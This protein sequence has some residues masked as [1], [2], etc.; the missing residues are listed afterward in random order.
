MPYLWRPFGV[1]MFIDQSFVNGLCNTLHTSLEP[2]VNLWA[3]HFYPVFA[4]SVLSLDVSN[5][6]YIKLKFYIPS[7]VFMRHSLDCDSVFS[8]LRSRSSILEMIHHRRSFAEGLLLLMFP[9]P[10]SMNSQT[11]KPDQFLKFSR[12]LGY[13]LRKFC[14]LAMPS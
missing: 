11:Q 5:R 13:P 8:L 6:L 4:F 12:K 3:A 9:H 2:R 10:F 1:D 14:L 7:F